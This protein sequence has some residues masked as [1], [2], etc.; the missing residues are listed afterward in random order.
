MLESSF[1]TQKAKLIEEY[2]RLGKEISRINSILLDEYDIE[3]KTK[4]VQSY[5][6]KTMS[7]IGSKFDFEKY[8][9]P[10]NLQ[11]SLDKF[12][13][14]HETSNGDKVP[15][16]AMG[17]GANWLYCH[18]TL[19]LALHHLFCDLG[20]KCL[21]PSFLFLDQPSQV[22]FPLTDYGDSFNAFK[23]VHTK[24]EKLPKKV[25]ED[26]L[27]V[28]NL[29]TELVEFCNKTYENTGIKPQIIVTDH[30]DHLELSNGH[31][32]EDF[33]K[34]RWRKEEE[35]FID[36]TVWEKDIKP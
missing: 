7:T 21:I 14:W 22:Y 25:D 4:K 32:F 13:L 34:A 31:V 26:L 17:S 11:F 10:I 23:L 9:Q 24:N 33:V 19:F 20:E 1:E 8:F 2:K 12:S 30:A 6:A 16:G 29:Y 28:Q 5:L 36:I 15:L 3:T 18:V 35:A 27:S